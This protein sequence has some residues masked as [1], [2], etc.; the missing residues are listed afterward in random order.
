MALNFRNF[1]LW[2]GIFLVVL[3]LVTVF[4]GPG[5][6][7]PGDIAYSQL[8][9]DVDSGRVHTIAIPGANEIK[10]TYTD[11]RS[12][13]TYAPADP[14]LAS[15]LQQKGVQVFVVAPSVDSTPWFIGLIVN[16]LPILVFIGAWLFLSQQM[17]RM[18][19]G[20]PSGRE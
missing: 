10:G 11:G 13:S 2:V 5:K 6:I 18:E 8:L 14:Q 19:P 3:A 17:R 12:F 9:A 7:R 16:W 4:Q 20:A 15:R 1:I